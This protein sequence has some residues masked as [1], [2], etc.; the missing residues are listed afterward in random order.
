MVRG[1]LLDGEMGLVDGIRVGVSEWC[2]GRGLVDGVGG[3]G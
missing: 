2:Q 3:G 1:G